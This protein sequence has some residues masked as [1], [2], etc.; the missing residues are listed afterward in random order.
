MCAKLSSRDLNLGHYPPHLTRTYTCGVI[1]APRV[2]GRFD[3]TMNIVG[4][5]AIAQSNELGLRLV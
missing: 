2:C 1:T 4:G 5:G 3:V